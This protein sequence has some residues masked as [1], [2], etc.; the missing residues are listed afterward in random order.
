MPRTVR[1]V[2]DAIAGG[3]GGRV[4]E[5]EPTTA[6][7]ARPISVP[8]SFRQQLRLRG[9]ELIEGRARP[10]GRRRDRPGP[11]L[12]EMHTIERINGFPAEEHALVVPFADLTAVRPDR[13]MTLETAGGP[14]S[15][16]LIDL[17]APIGFGQRALIVAPPRTGKTVLL[18]HIAQGIETNHPHAQVLIL[19][20]DERP[21]EV[22]H[23]RRNVPGEVVASSNDLDADHHVRVARL[24]VERAKRRVERGEDVVILLDSLTRVGRAFNHVTA[25]SSRTLSGG[26]DHRA[27]SE[28]K[29]LFGAARNLEEGGS[30][31]IIATALIET[32]SRMDEIIFSEFK[33]TGNME[34]VLSRDLADRRLFPA[35]DLAASGTRNEGDLLSPEELRVAAYMR[36]SLAGGDAVAGANGLLE[37]LRRTANNADLVAT[38]GGR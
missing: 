32:G 26:L 12:F 34:L 30:L 31:T 21:E 27:L 28:P 2:F 36:R 15:T 5:V 11:G 10:A 24:T 9:G 37:V 13:R 29:A 7:G 16:R 1:G 38:L 19:L 14:P 18:E 22:T 4:I 35:I 8:E 17:L 20:V 6:G 33:G 25:V 3:R 23:M